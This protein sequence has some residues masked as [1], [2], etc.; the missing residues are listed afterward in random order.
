MAEVLAMTR[1][2]LVLGLV[3]IDPT[4][5]GIFS[6]VPWRMRLAETLML[7]GIVIRHRLGRSAPIVKAMAHDFAAKCTSDVSV[8]ESLVRAYVASYSSTSQLATIGR[9]NRLSG[10]C[11]SWV[12]PIRERH[13]FPS[14]PIAMMMAGDKPLAELSRSLNET[15]SPTAERHIIAESGHYIHRDC[16]EAVLAALDGV[17]GRRG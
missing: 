8:Q 16:P 17:L 13:S 10:R 14:V 12:E 4:H 6:A 1:P 2:D 5:E 9:E 7:R 3:L 15:V 11:A